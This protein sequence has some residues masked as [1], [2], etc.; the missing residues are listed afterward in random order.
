MEKKE[1]EEGAECK[2]MRGNRREGEGEEKSK[3]D[4]VG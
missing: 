4:E 1:K 3:T 2:G